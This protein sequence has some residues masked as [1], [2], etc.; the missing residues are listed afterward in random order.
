MIADVLN[1]SSPV[2]LDYVCPN[3]FKLVKDKVKKCYKLR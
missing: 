3:I 1:N 2:E